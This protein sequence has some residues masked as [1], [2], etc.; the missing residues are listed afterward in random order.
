MAEQCS[1][2]EV[3]DTLVKLANQISDIASSSTGT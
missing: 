2:N 1:L 3:K